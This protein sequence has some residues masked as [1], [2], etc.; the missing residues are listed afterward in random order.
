MTIRT[1]SARWLPFLALA[2]ITQVTTACHDSS[3]QSTTELRAI[4]ASSDA[5][6]VDVIVNGK[7]QLT[8]VPYETASAFLQIPAG[9]TTLAVNPTGTSTS[10]INTTLALAADQQ[11]TAIVVG[12]AE[13]SAPEGEGIQAVLVD[14]PGNA[15]ASGNVKVRVVHG[16]PG[17]PTVDIYVTAPGVALPASPSIPGLQ[18][19]AVAPA[20]GSKALEL[21]GGSY[22]IRATVTGDQSKTVV[23]DS[24]TVSLPANADLLVTAIPASGVSPVSL[25][26]AAAGSSASVIADSRTAIRVGHLSPNVPAVDVSLNDAGT[27]TNVLSLTD[28]SYPADSGYAIVPTATY[29]AS[30]ALASNPDSPVLTLKGA[31]LAANT[32]TSVFAIGLLGGTGAQ[33]LQLAAF[34]DDRVPVE[35]KAK[36]RVIHL[37][38]D[39]PAVDVVA[40]GSG[41]TIGATLVSD[42]SYPNATAADLQVAPGS[43]TLAVVP[44]GT[45]SPLLPTAAGVAVTLTAGEVVTVAAIGCLNTTSG[46]CANGSP[47]ALKVLSDN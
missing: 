36:V 2:A 28:V 19:T 21:T 37:A 29:D 9:T 40:L 41:G 39:A 43:Y 14:D 18:Y 1:I 13:S 34:A 3:D 46:P 38:P 4:H 30:V 16:A 12:L 33:T 27:S 20:S 6:N 11:Y 17:V 32:S 23:F 47:F 42:I 22:E 35:G 45:T 7:A 44:T 26:V 8:N 15:P 24:G 5:P 10:V 31:S 25:L